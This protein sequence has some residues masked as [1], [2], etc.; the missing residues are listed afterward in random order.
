MPSLHFEKGFVKS[1][2]VEKGYGFIIPYEG[3][4]DVFV[5]QSAIKKNGFRSLAQGEEV[6]FIRLVTHKGARALLVTG[7]DGANC[8]GIPQSCLQK[9]VTPCLSQENPSMVPS[10]LSNKMSKHFN[11]PPKNFNNHSAPVQ[12]GFNCTSPYLMSSSRSMSAE[13][14]GCSPGHRSPPM[15]KYIQ[16][17]P[18]P[19]TN[20]R[21]Y[22]NSTSR[23]ASTRSSFRR[24]PSDSSY[25]TD[26]YTNYPNEMKLVNE[27]IKKLALQVDCIQRRVE[28][29]QHHPQHVDDYGQAY[30][31]SQMAGKETVVQSN[32]KFQRHVEQDIHRLRVEQLLTM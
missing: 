10:N 13:I 22:S 12:N 5:P 1:Y 27:F 4:A 16:R 32:K 8:K 7:P 26:T 31:R 6:Q 18:S 21:S 24:S 14:R 17:T 29:I 9:I 23:S 11:V 25:S 3:K 30:R 2:N 15:R 19:P 20:R 28:F